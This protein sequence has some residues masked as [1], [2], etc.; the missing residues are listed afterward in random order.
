M[1]GNSH[2]ELVV[3]ERRRLLRPPFPC[4]YWIRMYGRP[5]PGGG[6]SLAHL[7]WERTKKQHDFKCLS[8][9]NMLRTHVGHCATLGSSGG[10]SSAI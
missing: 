8:V 7:A 6:G 2:F 5:L 10:V 4:S 9:N 3:C 1:A